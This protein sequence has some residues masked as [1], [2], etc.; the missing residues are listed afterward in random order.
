MSDLDLRERQELCDLFDQL[1]PDAPTLCEGWTT[2]DLAAHL[3]IREHD[4]LAAPGVLLEGRLGPVGDK[5]AGVTRS[6]ME[7]EL[8][9]GYE[10]V[11]ER[12][13]TG[14]PPPLSFAPI[15]SRMSFGEFLIHHEDVRRANGQ[16]PRRD[17]PDLDAQVWKLLKPMARLLLRKAKPVGVV[18]RTDKGQESAATKGAH[19]VVV[20]GSPVELLL[21]CY[22]RPSEVTLEGPDEA[23]AALRATS[24]GI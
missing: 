14:P 8:E 23:V 4:L 21:F 1:G 18:L 22:G 10:G 13:R 6:H 11:V 3:A 17:R 2:A 12:V 5:L 9:R 20:S 16:A 24:L 7:R 19:Q 15:R